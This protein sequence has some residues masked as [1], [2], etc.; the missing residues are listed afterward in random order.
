MQA[1]AELETDTPG[2]IFGIT[3]KPDGKSK[4]ESSAMNETKIQGENDSNYEKHDRSG[5][6]N[7]QSKKE[8]DNHFYKITG[9]LL[10]VVICFNILHSDA[11][12]QKVEYAIARQR[13][14]RIPG[15]EQEA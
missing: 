12:W 2:T 11:N 6:E 1:Y 8:G 13:G 15:D 7:Y 10:I 3:Q 5:D 14:I 9:F 4:S